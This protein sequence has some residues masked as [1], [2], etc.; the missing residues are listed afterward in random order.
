MYVFMYRIDSVKSN[1]V[2][3]GLEDVGGIFPMIRMTNKGI[4]SFVQT[5]RCNFYLIDITCQ[6]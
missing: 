6:T 2:Y 1:N 3:L 5:T 4:T